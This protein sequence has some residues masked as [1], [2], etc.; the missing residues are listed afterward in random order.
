[1][2]NVLF[3]LKKREELDETGKKKLI[4][5][6]LYNSSTYLNTILNNMHID[7]NIEIAIDNNCIDRLV[8]KHRPKYVIIEALWVVPS[9][10]DILCRL[11]PTVKWII[12]VSYTHLTLP[13]IYS[14]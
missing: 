12:P 8:T 7:S 5:T 4:E 1:M 10:F 9:K 3:I 2:S 6:G 13:T 14:V 11:H